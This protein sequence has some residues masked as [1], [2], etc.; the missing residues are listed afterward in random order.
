MDI[1]QSPLLSVCPAVD[2][3]TRRIQVRCTVDN[4]GLKLRPE[5]Y[6]RVS[7]LGNAQRVAVRI[8]NSALVTDGLYSFVFV[9]REAGVF[10]RRKV[11]LVVQD[12]EFSYVAS[13]LKPD[14]RVV[15]RGALLLNSELAAG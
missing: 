9:E 3:A 8:P 7:L 5:M 6:A 12:R 4:A 15:V 2:P 1:A 14:E 13:G 10:E 11:E